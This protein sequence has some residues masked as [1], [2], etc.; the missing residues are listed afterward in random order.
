MPESIFMPERREEISLVS[1]A[2]AK[3]V[4]INLEGDSADADAASQS[5]FSSMNSTSSISNSSRSIPPNTVD[6]KAKSRSNTQELEG[7][8][9]TLLFTQLVKQLENYLAPANLCHDTYLKTLQSLN[10][11]CVPCAV[12]A[13][14]ANI[15]AL[16]WATP[17]L[18]RRFVTDESRMQILR[19]AVQEVVPCCGGGMTVVAIDRASGVA[20]RQESVALEGTAA[21]IWAVR[22]APDKVAS[23]E[24]HGATPSDALSPTQNAPSETVLLRDVQPTVTEE[25][26]RNL[27]QQQL[28]DSPRV[29]SVSLHGTNC[30]YVCSNRNNLV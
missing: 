12:L 14:L 8:F 19:Q 24:A 15:K 26:V 5:A 6:A 21:T 11:G 20:V 18:T 7:T 2:E 25:E 30:W 17:A 22:P 16:L 28:P 3:F 23:D 13:N 27:L 10:D 4:L 9:R 29:V 1:S